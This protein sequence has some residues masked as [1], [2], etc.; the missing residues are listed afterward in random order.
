MTRA[1]TKGQPA[2]FA[3]RQSALGEMTAKQ[4]SL[5]LGCIAADALVIKDMASRCADNAPDVTAVNSY[6]T[7]IEALSEKLAWMADTASC[8]T[9]GATGFDMGVAESPADLFFPP[10]FRM[11]G[12]APDG[13]Q[14]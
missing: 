9:P 4:I 3:V 14:A 1:A 11:S 13:E 12:H 8:G 5:A 10:A 7:A 6:C 2:P